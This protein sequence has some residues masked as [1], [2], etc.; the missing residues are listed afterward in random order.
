MTMQS[1]G[2]WNPC[3]ASCGCHT[4]TKLCDC[5]SSLGLSMLVGKKAFVK[6]S[7]NKIGLFGDVYDESFELG[8]ANVTVSPIPVTY[9]C[10]GL[11][12]FYLKKDG[13]IRLVGNGK[14]IYAGEGIVNGGDARDAGRHEGEADRLG[15]INRYVSVHR[16]NHLATCM[17]MFYCDDYSAPAAVS[18]AG[19]DRTS[20]SAS[21]GYMNV[22]NPYLAGCRVLYKGSPIATLTSIGVGNRICN[23]GYA[24]VPE[25]GNYYAL[26]WMNGDVAHD[27]QSSFY[28]CGTHYAQI[29]G[30]AFYEGKF[31]TACYPDDYI[32]CQNENAVIPSPD[33]TS[34]GFYR[35]G[36]LL[37]RYP[38]NFVGGTGSTLHHA[39]MAGRQVFG[40]GRLCY[41]GEVVYMSGAAAAVG[42]YMF[43]GSRYYANETWHS[44][45]Y[46]GKEI[47]V[48]ETP[49]NSTDRFAV[50]DY[51]L[52]YHRPLQGYSR[53]VDYCYFQGNLVFDEELELVCAAGKSIAVKKDNHLIIYHAGEKVHDRQHDEIAGIPSR[54]GTLFVRADERIICVDHDWGLLQFN[55]SH[56]AA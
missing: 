4:E 13:H 22:V 49:E 14:E 47:R 46:N 11:S 26:Y 42:R 32:I 37:H 52:L 30:R 16:P 34:C 23:G 24:F 10:R 29:G 3:R 19:T 39:V 33:G 48:L 25:A 38:I 1:F 21:V 27:R 7:R 43:L 15:T 44:I 9:S 55:V 53:A 50:A 8:E 17:A 36:N 6:Y 12:Y 45:Y 18:L 31:L 5:E 41:D 54:N 56:L 20:G 35:Y 2:R 40:S 51:D 28:V